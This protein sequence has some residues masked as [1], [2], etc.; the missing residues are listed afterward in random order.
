MKL[1]ILVLTLFVSILSGHSQEFKDLIVTETNDSISCTISLLNDKNFFYD[2][3]VKNGI[4]NDMMPVSKVKY[5][6]Y[7]GKTNVP[8]IQSKFE[9]KPFTWEKTDS[10]AKTKAQIYSDTKMFIAITWKSAKNVIQNDDKEGGIILLKGSTTREVFCFGTTWYYVY[11]YNVTFRMKDN[12][13]KIVID[14]LYCES[15]YNSKGGVPNKIEPFLGDQCP[16]NVSMGFNT[17]GIPK[18]QAIS[19]MASLLNDFQ[20]IVD[21]YVKYINASSKAIGEW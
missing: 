20:P 2:H 1:F 11:Y 14:N 4:V 15:A 5:Y 17:P 8:V 19:M 9:T 13:F 10:V 7:G 18:K 12:K 3:K 21:D 16:Q 6:S